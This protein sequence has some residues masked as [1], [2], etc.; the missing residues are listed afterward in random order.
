MLKVDKMKGKHISEDTEKV[1]KMF[2][3]FA[4]R[5]ALVRF[6]M[7]PHPE[8]GAPALSV[9]CG[10]FGFIYEEVSKGEFSPAALAALGL[11][12][13]IAKHPGFLRQLVE[14]GKESLD[15]DFWEQHLE[16]DGTETVQ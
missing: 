15:T 3:E 1:L 9:G 4:E 14:A 2:S 12:Y 6:R 7:E 8:T 13:Y 11:Q 16:S 10:L 5:A